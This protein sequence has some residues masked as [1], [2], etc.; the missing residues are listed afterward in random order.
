MKK[1]LFFHA[2]W[3]GPCKVYDQEI[4]APLEQL[5]GSDRIERID[6]W[7]E[8]FKA[9]KYHVEKLPTVVLLDGETVY[10]NRTG[11]IEID[12]VAEWLKGAVDND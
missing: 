12:K 5:V 3:C 6:A 9:E 1:L 2:S 8:P 4:I 10:M 11:A 7:K